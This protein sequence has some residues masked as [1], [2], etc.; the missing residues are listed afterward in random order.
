MRRFGVIFVYR[1]FVSSFIFKKDGFSRSCV[2][3]SE[4]LGFRV[5]LVFGER[6]CRVVV[7]LADRL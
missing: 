2:I 6:R 5:S 4:M 3:V 1:E 7:K